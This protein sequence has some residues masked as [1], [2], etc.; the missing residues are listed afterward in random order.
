MCICFRI[1]M[2]FIWWDWI[3]HVSSMPEK[4]SATQYIVARHGQRF[5]PNTTTCSWATRKPT[6][7]HSIFGEWYDT[8]LIW[9]FK[10]W[11]FQLMVWFYKQPMAW[12]R[13]DHPMIPDDPLIDARPNDTVGQ[14]RLKHRERSFPKT[15]ALETRF[16]G[17]I[18]SIRNHLT[19][20]NLSGLICWLKKSCG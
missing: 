16:L 14:N 11:G 2:E 1:L 8:T 10:W 9:G 5:K 18:P 13:K 7:D 3:T 4:K 20:E 19:I 17:G 6:L 15:V 12:I